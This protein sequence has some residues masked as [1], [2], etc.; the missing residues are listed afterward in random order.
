MFRIAMREETGAASPRREDPGGTIRR[1]KASATAGGVGAAPPSL[2]RMG[3]TATLSGM[4]CWRILLICVPVAALAVT[5]P[6]ATEGEV[7]TAI[8]RLGSE[9]HSDRKEAADLLVELGEAAIAPLERAAKSKDPEIR[10]RAREILREIDERARALPAVP[11]DLREQLAGK[12]PLDRKQVIKD[13][14]AKGPESYKTVYG[15]LM[16]EQDEEGREAVLSSLAEASVRPHD[17]VL[18]DEWG[19]RL[20]GAYLRRQLTTALRCQSYA[21]WSLVTGSISNDIAELA[22]QPV[23]Q[24]ED[25]A[26]ALLSWLHFANGDSQ[27]ANALARDRKIRIA[28]PDLDIEAGDAEPFDMR[29]EALVTSPSPRR[30]AATVAHSR[31]MDRP[32]TLDAVIKALESVAGVA[33]TTR[34]E[35]TTTDELVV[36]ALLVADRPRIALESLVKRRSYALAF[37][38]CRA[39]GRYA[40]ALE[41]A[42]K[43]RAK[44]PILPVDL[45]G[46]E[47]RLREF[48]D[49]PDLEAELKSLREGLD[50]TNALPAIRGIVWIYLARGQPDRAKEFCR[51]ASVELDASA[52]DIALGLSSEAS[53]MWSWFERLHTAESGRRRLERV[54]DHL[55][56]PQR[57][58]AFL[59]VL[60]KM[61]TAADAD[62]DEMAS[63]RRCWRVGLICLRMLPGVETMDVI[64][65]ETAPRSK[66]EPLACLGGLAAANG[67]WE[68]A[69]T[70]FKR[71]MDDQRY[72][73]G[74]RYMY[75]KA[76]SELGRKE[77]GAQYMLQGSLLPLAS[78]HARCELLRV[79]MLYG[80]HEDAVAQWDI[81]RRACC[82]AA[83]WRPAGF[84]FAQRLLRGE[85]SPEVRQRLLRFMR[86]HEGA[87]GY[88]DISDRLHDAAEFR[89][90]LAGEA[91]AAGNLDGAVAL[92]DRAWEL[93]MVNVDLFADGVRLLQAADRVADAERLYK[94]TVDVLLANSRL[95]PDCAHCRNVLAWFMARCHRDLDAARKHAETAVRLQPRASAYMDTL[96]EIMFHLGDREKAVE[97]QQKAVQY[98]PNMREL[99]ERLE[100]FRKEA[101]PTGPR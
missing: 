90:T 51:R 101:I 78:H 37:E 48:H 79:L 100:G 42:E 29:I 58:K 99:R 31:A 66:S 9:T 36:D 46:A 75:G 88:G 23:E 16:S 80:F 17:L 82:F 19:M 95:F 35:N 57:A 53:L 69:A 12:K 97:L 61:M 52:E 94:R 3:D 49:T 70:W 62:P 38:F 2:P 67:D 91:V 76:L 5:C 4:Q 55:A 39:R 89:C 93:S 71:A 21:V 64:A 68:T 50:G 43:A 60:A 18:G 13:L 45:E 26:A 28:P 25:D 85:K 30:L 81:A 77:E 6:G 40:D 41:I 96:A 34:H 33:A 84:R 98:A 10:L 15:L 56:K 63:R 92:Y 7:T 83:A 11:E 65:F 20:L 1:L 59:P 72:H 8:E 44:E 87:K 74:A 14:L 22:A 47:E 86:I 32:E 54:V 24:L 73:P 27:K